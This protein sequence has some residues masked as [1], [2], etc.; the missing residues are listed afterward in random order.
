M[1]AENLF[2]EEKRA[3]QFCDCYGYEGKE[4]DIAFNAF[5]TGFYH[6]F[7]KAEGDDSDS[8]TDYKNSL[9]NDY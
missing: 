3:T 1:E 8:Q 5:V 6:G 7:S 4:R 9:K 2:Y